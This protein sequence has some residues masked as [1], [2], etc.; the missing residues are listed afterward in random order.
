MPEPRAIGIDARMLSPSPTGVG[1][2][3][4][5]LL[6]PLCN[7]HP[8]TRFILYS[9]SKVEFDGPANVVVREGGPSLGPLWMN[10]MLPQTMTEDGIDVFWGANGVTPCLGTA[11]PSVVTVHDLVYRFAGETMGRGARWNKW[12]FQGWSVRRAKQVVA[13][14]QA[15]ANDVARVYGRSVDTVLRPRP[16][17]EFSRRSMDC[18]R[19]VCDR[20]KLP[21]RFW[22]FAGTLEP[23]KNLVGLLDAYL[24]E[25][26]AGKR[27]PVLALAGTRGWS[28]ERLNRL[29]ARGESIG[30]VRRLGYVS[31]KDL[32]T[33][34][35][36]CIL[37][38]MPS[39]YEGFGLPLL[40]AQQC[41]AAVVH[42]DHA[43]M[44]EAADGLGVVTGTDVGALRRAIDQIV[45]GEA[46]L[47]CRIALMP[48]DDARTA[49]EV[50][51]G[52]FHRAFST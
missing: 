36:G 11:V 31:V 33:L 39:L 5:N 22:L 37:L 38:W 6:H 24:Q 52:C 40:E 16:N 51:W 13:V 1:N 49:S 45:R 23:R 21:E 4:A 35:S 2:Y 8:H 48:P 15:T 26:D 32:A 34:Y 9:N 28:D 46:P 12:A 50:L 14:S 27:L 30:Q 41:G 25:I 18:I 29:I 44:C 42:G 47:T 17:A 20:L 10:V 19:E 3:I 7:A 43:S